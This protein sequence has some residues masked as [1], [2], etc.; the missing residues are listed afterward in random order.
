MRVRSIITALAC[1]LCIRATLNQ[2]VAYGDDTLQTS[3]TGV[4]CFY[5]GRNAVDLS[6]PDDDPLKQAA[7]NH[8]TAKNL[9]SIAY[10][11]TNGTEHLGDYTYHVYRKTIICA[12]GR[13]VGRKDVL[14]TCRYSYRDNDFA[15]VAYNLTCSTIHHNG[16]APELDHCMRDLEAKN[17]TS[18]DWLQHLGLRVTLV[19]GGLIGIPA[20]ILGLI[21]GVAWVRGQINARPRG[22]EEAAPLDTPAPDD[23]EGIELQDTTP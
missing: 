19:V 5:A 13:R 4:M 1:A 23:E 17:T 14:T 7:I 20:A 6:C 21:T 18:H 16:A 22:N 10:F 15:D 11:N 2:T 9:S 12:T 3:G 8:S